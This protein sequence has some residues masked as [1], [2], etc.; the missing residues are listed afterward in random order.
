MISDETRQ[1]IEHAAELLGYSA[2]LAARGLRTGKSMMV[3]FCVADLANPF[4]A[5]IVKSAEDVLA[6]EGYWSVLIANYE[7]PELFREAA[8]R[9]LD[10]GLDGLIISSARF[11]DIDFVR[12][13]AKRVPI[14]LAIRDLG[15]K[16]FF[17]VTHDDLLGGKMAAEHLIDLGHTEVAEIRGPVDVSSFRGRSQ[18][19]KSE[20]RKS[21]AQD[22]SI[23]RKF[24]PPTSEG[25]Y[26]AAK[27]LLSAGSY[28]SGLFAHND[29]MAV[30]ALEALAEQGITCPSDISIVG[31]NDSPLTEHLNP[32]LTT[33]RL[34]G[35]EVGELAASHLLTQLRD[36]SA[37]PMVER[38]P[39]EIIVRSST[40][41]FRKQKNTQ[42]REK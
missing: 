16:E 15:T 4:L 35:A 10:R 24:Y 32:P 11:S 40:Q 3:G 36:P 19:F 38:I 25:G 30:G 21:G 42:R 28:P 13:L 5:P 7:D 20:V 8:N 26:Q 9:L 22:L 12:S 37:T 31:Y 29:V 14:V 27:D 39:P 41:K 6:D 34:S 1:K 2:N 33:I 17:S 18:G 23:P